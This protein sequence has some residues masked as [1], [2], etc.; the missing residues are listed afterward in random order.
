MGKNRF[1][2]FAEAEVEELPEEVEAVETVEIVEEPKRK[3][4]ET[5]SSFVD[6]LKSDGSEKKKNYQFTLQP[7]QREKLS[8]ITEKLGVRSDSALFGEMIDNLYDEVFDE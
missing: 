5:S 3:R 8:K 7:T 1:I 4:K 2:K 6:R